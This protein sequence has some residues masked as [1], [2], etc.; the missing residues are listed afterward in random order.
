MNVFM[1]KIIQLVK[2]F[3]TEAEHTNIY[4]SLCNQFEM[5]DRCN[6]KI[7]CI[8]TQN[9]QMPSVSNQIIH[10]SLIQNTIKN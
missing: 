7:T 5:L 3:L 8:S 9:Y 1:H 6:W 2:T 10:C 4:Q